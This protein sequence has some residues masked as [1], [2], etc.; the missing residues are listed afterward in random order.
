MRARS[1]IIRIGAGSLGVGLLL[2]AA[3]GLLTAGT[4]SPQTSATT[5]TSTS[6]TTTAPP[7][8]STTAA[9]APP[10]V[11]LEFFASPADA[12]CTRGELRTRVVLIWSSQGADTVSIEADGSAIVTDAGPTSRRAVAIDCPF[13]NGTESHDLQLTATA[14]DGGT[15]TK[16]TTVTVTGPATATTRGRGDRP[17]APDNPG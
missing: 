11:V 17:V 6:T 15:A 4:A 14:A 1:G 10:P 5:T 3:V 12:V 13:S 9:T 8:P 16:S 2:G 7:D